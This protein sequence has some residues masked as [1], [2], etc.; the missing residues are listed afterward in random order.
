MLGDW[1]I[2]FA[3]NSTISGFDHSSFTW[4]FLGGMGSLYHIIQRRSSNTGD[5]FLAQ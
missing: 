3:Y 2:P 1:V 4:I 5:A